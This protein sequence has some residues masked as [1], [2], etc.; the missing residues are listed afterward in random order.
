M[1]EPLRHKSTDLKIAKETLVLTR[2]KVVEQSSP[3]FTLFLLWYRLHSS[4]IP[5]VVEKTSR[6]NV[7]CSIIMQAI[8]VLWAEIFI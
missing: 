3:F 8:Y 5:L 7:P 1:R 6:V 2:A 4:A